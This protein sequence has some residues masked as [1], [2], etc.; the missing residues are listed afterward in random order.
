MTRHST[1]ADIARTFCCTPGGTKSKKYAEDHTLHCSRRCGHVRCALHI[2]A[3]FCKPQ[4]LR[5]VNHSFLRDVMALSGSLVDFVRNLLEHIQRHVQDLYSS[6][7]DST[8]AKWK[9]ALVSISRLLSTFV[10]C[11]RARVA[12]QPALVQQLVD[13]L[14]RCLPS[15]PDTTDLPREWQECP[16]TLLAPA[17]LPSKRARIEIDA[18]AHTVCELSAHAGDSTQVKR[19]AEAGAEC[20]SSYPTFPLFFAFMPLHMYECADG[21]VVYDSGIG[22]DVMDTKRW[23]VDQLSSNPKWLK[24]VT[25][26][27]QVNLNVCSSMRSFTRYLDAWKLRRGC[28]SL[29]LAERWLLRVSS[30]YS[31]TS[32]IC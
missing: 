12:A 20:S 5:D 21:T 24:M 23:L 9:L 2:K 18:R 8:L 26:Y 27:S 16:Q 14:R 10:L 3:L 28:C 32:W 4:A 19:V 6:H 30:Y 29:D 31:I 11:T 22:Y 1:S 25:S 7:H 13:I 17:T 15:P